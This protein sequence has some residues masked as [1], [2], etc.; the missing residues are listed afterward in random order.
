MRL[1]AGSEA[2]CFQDKK[3]SFNYKLILYAVPTLS[4]I[5]NYQSNKNHNWQSI[6]E[7][8]DLII[9]K[10]NLYKEKFYSN[11]GEEKLLTGI[12]YYE[13]GIEGKGFIREN[14]IDFLLRIKNVNKETLTDKLFN[15]EHYRRY[16]SMLGMSNF[17]KN[18]LK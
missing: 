13:N 14:S 4:E 8:V 6:D 12:I 18:I 3:F 16:A 2:N 9:K 7:C 17:A 11:Y 5:K 15:I 10:V 1:Q